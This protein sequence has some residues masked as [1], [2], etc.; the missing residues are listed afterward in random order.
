MNHDV[1]H[2]SEVYTLL[3]IVPVRESVDL[4]SL[5]KQTIGI[6]DRFTGTCDLRVCVC[7][8][9]SGHEECMLCLFFY[10]SALRMPTSYRSCMM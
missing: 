3:N 1:L 2:L 4:I 10:L 9:S 7:V 6:A 8:F 5:S